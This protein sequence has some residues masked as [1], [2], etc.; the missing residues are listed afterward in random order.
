MAAEFQTT[1]TVAFTRVNE[2]LRDRKKSNITWL[3]GFVIR[4]SL[5]LLIVRWHFT[6]RFK[7]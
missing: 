7:M 4:I 2:T 1:V 5:L 6:A 3:D